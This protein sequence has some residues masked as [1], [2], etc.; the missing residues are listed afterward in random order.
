MKTTHYIK[1]LLERPFVKR[2][3]QTILD[4]N[5]N[6]NI[7]N[8]HKNGEFNF[9]ETHTNT[10]STIFDVG[11]NVGEWA[12]KA[13]LCNKDARIHCFEP[14]NA[15][16]K[17]LQ[18]KKFSSE[19]ILNNFALGDAIG[20]SEIALFN[21]D[22]GLNSIYKEIINYQTIES[23]Q[24]IEIDTIDEYC[25][26]NQI[27][28]IS[29]LK[30]DVEGHEVSVLRGAKRMIKEKRIDWIQF[31]YGPSYVE[32]RTYLKDVFDMFK[33]ENVRF[34]KIHPTSLRLVPAYSYDIEHFRYANYVIQFL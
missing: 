22:S 28:R 19:L 34:Y 29:L 30:I 8:M 10:F 12:H 20:K 33:N 25:A 3:A 9:L 24:E 18:S 5:Q 23:I 31:E 27:E 4:I 1:K 17:I 16:F 15:T 21:G 7:G 26:R 13:L 2:I 6:E 14:V 32:A 11:A